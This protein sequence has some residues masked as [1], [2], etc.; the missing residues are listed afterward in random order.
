MLP[1]YNPGNNPVWVKSCTTSPLVL[2]NEK[3]KN[4]VFKKILRK[5]CG[6]QKKA[7]ASHNPVGVMDHSSM[8][9]W[10]ERLFQVVEYDRKKTLAKYEILCEASEWR[11]T[12]Q[13]IWLAMCK[14]FI[15]EVL[16]MRW[17]YQGGRIPREHD[18]SVAE[19]PRNH[20]TR[21]DFS[22]ES[23]YTWTDIP[24]QAWAWRKVCY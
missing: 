1:G 6:S 11:K 7:Q 8:Y 16:S 23:N 22:T 3:K 20:Q 5:T 13:T 14:Y 4:S 18:I 15:K 17:Y 19:S 24:T 9:W 21:G 12:A 2:L 10:L